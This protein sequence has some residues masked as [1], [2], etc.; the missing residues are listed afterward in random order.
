AR[1]ARTAAVGAYRAG[2]TAEGAAGLR[3]AAG[4]VPDPDA[5]RADCDAL[6][7]AA[8][9]Q[10]WPL[11]SFTCGLPAAGVFA[12]LAAAVIPAG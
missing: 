5:E 12:R 10:A 11:V 3:T 9:G 7:T 2:L 6:L 4:V 1:A 8:E